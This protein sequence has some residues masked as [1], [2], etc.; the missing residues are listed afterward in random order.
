MIQTMLIIWVNILCVLFLLYVYLK[1][2]E[3]EPT[4][5]STKVKQWLMILSAAGVFTKLG[6]SL[7]FVLIVVSIGWIIM[8][9]SNKKEHV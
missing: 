5:I 1:V 2:S 3:K 8:L 7:I 6:R 9:K 4:K